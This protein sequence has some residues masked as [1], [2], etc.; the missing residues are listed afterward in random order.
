[1]RLKDTKC[2]V[3]VDTDVTHYYISEQFFNEIKELNYKIKKPINNKLIIANG[4]E[5]KIIG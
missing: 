4:Q 5:W 3:L 2:K 1:M